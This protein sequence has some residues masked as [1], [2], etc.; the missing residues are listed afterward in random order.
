MNRL[1]HVTVLKELLIEKIS[2]L[3][4]T[5]ETKDDANDELL[6]EISDLT[7]KVGTKEMKKADDL[8]KLKKQVNEEK[9]KS[10]SRS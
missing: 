3:K 8:A 4:Q 10:G 6:R 1:V 7:I 9:R 5:I 2:A